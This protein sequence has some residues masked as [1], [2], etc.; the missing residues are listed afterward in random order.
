[1][2]LSV[3]GAKGLV[4]RSYVPVTTQGPASTGGVRPVDGAA[5]PLT[6]PRDVFVPSAGQQAGFQAPYGPSSSGA[7]APAR[8]GEEGGSSPVASLGGTGSK[9]PNAF[10]PKECKT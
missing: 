1:M 3:P 5:S 4:D 10:D 6:I 2:G 7:G 8:G 9:G